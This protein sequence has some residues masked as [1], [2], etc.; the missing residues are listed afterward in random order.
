MLSI[1]I[2]YCTFSLVL[3]FFASFSGV[4]KFNDSNR[5]ANYTKLFRNIGLFHYAPITLTLQTGKTEV[6]SALLSLVVRLLVW[7]VFIHH[8]NID[9]SL[10]Q[11]YQWDQ[12]LYIFEHLRVVNMCAVNIIVA[13]GLWHTGKIFEESQE[14]VRV[15]ANTFCVAYLNIVTFRLVGNVERGTSKSS[16]TPFP[17]HAHTYLYIENIV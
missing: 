11:L 12:L 15:G 3:C 7:A 16:P 13:L 2:R 10:S 9:R 4:C 8:K 14:S 1:S 5:T 6:G 17:Q